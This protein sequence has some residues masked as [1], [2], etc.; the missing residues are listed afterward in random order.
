MSQ[1]MRVAFVTPEFAPLAT[2]G[3]QPDFCTAL[4]RR[5][6]SHGVEVSVFMPKYRTREIESLTLVPVSPELWVPVGEEKVKASVFRGE[7]RKQTI[8]FIDNP[9][10]FLRDKIYG[11]PSGHYL[12]NDERFV[13][14]CRAVLEFLL[15][16]G[17]AFDVIHCN[18]W[19]S[20]LIPV[21][22]KTHYAGA[23][24]FRDVAAV[25]TVLDPGQEGEFPAES[26]AWTGLNWDL[27]TPE[28]LA[29]NGRFNFLKAGLIFTD[30]VS[31]AEAGS[32]GANRVEKFGPGLGEVLESRKEVCYSIRGG[33]GCR[34]YV[35]VYRIALELK[36]G[37]HIVH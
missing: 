25:L 36:R 29:L 23:F 14:F 2:E 17:L 7:V 26:L 21:F 10:Y 27:F 11:P 15:Q 37:G 1:K 28:K 13:F 34:D 12:D 3:S 6:S 4:P 31:L 35:R 16:G 30:V 20:A 18:H 9:K 19:P 5:L 24:P 8:Y 32:P 22:L 33:N